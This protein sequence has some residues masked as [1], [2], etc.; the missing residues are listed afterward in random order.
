MPYARVRRARIY[1]E[2]HGS[3]E[4]LLLLSGFT[5]SGTV[6]EPVLPLWSGRFRC[7]TYDHRGSG[8]SSPA[9][10]GLSM[11]ALAG[12]AVGLLDHL[13]IEAAHVF[14]L[15]MGGMVAQEMALRFPDRVRGLV[16]GGTSPGGPRATLPWRELS[17]LAPAV[18]GSRRGARLRVLER[19]LF[20]PGFRRDHPDRVAALV[21]PFL[22]HRSGPRGVAAQFWASVYHDTW[23]RLPQVQAPTLVLHGGAD[24]LAPL[25]SA[26]ALARRVPGAELVVLPGAGHAFPLERPQ[27]TLDVVTAWLE[28]HGPVPPGRPLTRPARVAEPVTRHLGLGAGALRTGRS[29]VGLVSAASSAGPRRPRGTPPG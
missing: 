5:V 27:E 28:R 2:E 7:V 17:G 9:S 20:S 8:R 1:H 4:P 6:F 19:A 16:L 13:G 3:G 24:G 11:P 15:S 18:A 12:D 22:R 21:Q 10:V 23:A 14:G 29:A 26:R 25:G